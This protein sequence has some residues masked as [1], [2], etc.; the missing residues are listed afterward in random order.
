[1]PLPRLVTISKVEEL[2]VVA[3]FG[4]LPLGNYS[5]HRLLCQ[6]QV[7]H[8]Y[9]G[10]SMPDIVSSRD[11]MTSLANRGFVRVELC[12]SVSSEQRE[13]KMKRSNVF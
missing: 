12:V 2:A 8:D 5:I 3:A 13:R 11:L 10:F 7:R 6:L 9:Q 1:M 4:A